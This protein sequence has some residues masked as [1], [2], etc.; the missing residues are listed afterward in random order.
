MNLRVLI[1]VLLFLALAGVIYYY[2]KEITEIQ[3]EIS[4]VETSI[5]HTQHELA[6]FAGLEPDTLMVTYL[7]ERINF[8]DYW[9]F[10]NGKFF[11][12]EDSSMITWTYM[13]SIINRFNQ[14]FQFNFSTTTRTG[15]A[16][17]DYTVTG[18]GSIHD[19]YAFISHVERLGALY[20]IE[21]VT[22]SSGLIESEVGAPINLVTY[23]VLIRP[24]VDP[25][26]GKRLN[27]QSLRRIQYTPLLR[28]PMRAA[29]HQPIPNP[30]QERLISYEDLR[31]VSFSNRDAYFTLGNTVVTLRPM[32]RVAYGYFSHVDSANNRAV[33][34]INRTG[35]YETVFQELK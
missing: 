13:Q 24:W 9:V 8:I 30:L 31:L 2:H 3:E 1:S 21:N 4:G 28:D 12:T 27:D 15:G 7:R 22:L 18:S 5:R 26:I 20:T 35:L 17:N 19:L 33:F 29:I 32:E 25:A 10:H 11:L 34:R 6:G 23:N 16:G 14:N